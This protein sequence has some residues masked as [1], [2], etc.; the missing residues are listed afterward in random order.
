MNEEIYNYLQKVRKLGTISYDIRLQLCEYYKQVFNHEQNGCLT[1]G[2]CLRTA[3]WSLIETGD[4]WFNQPKPAP[5]IEA[6]EQNPDI[7][8]I[9]PFNK[10]KK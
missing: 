4:R 6:K 2:E 9:K 3:F 1:C 10:K 5:I 8:E 7:E